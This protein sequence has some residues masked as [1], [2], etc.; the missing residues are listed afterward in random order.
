M[1]ILTFDIEDWWIYGHYNIGKKEDWLPRL[2]NYLDIILDLLDERK[3]EATFFILGILAKDNPTVVKRISSR[4]HHIGCHSFLHTFWTEDSLPEEVLSDTQ[5]ALD[6]IQNITGEKVDTYRAPAFSITESSSWIL[7]IL[8]ESGIKYDCSIFPANRS[9]GGFSSFSEA[10]PSLIDL[11]NDR[12][13][14]EFP[15][16]P[17]QIINKD[18]VYSGGGYFRLFPY[19]LTKFFVEKS[20]YVM[21]YFHIKDFDK[22]QEKQYFSFQGESAFS[23]YIKNYCGLNNS[24]SKFTNLVSQFDFVSVRQADRLLQWEN[25]PLLKLFPNV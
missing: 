18:I 7:S 17:V 23:R 21:T 11:N 14:K 13:I 4:G 16:A 2:D 12:Y 1:N 24:F 10:K 15:I 25:Q 9:Y 20:D 19:Q 5:K 8:E 6:I 22:K 3:I